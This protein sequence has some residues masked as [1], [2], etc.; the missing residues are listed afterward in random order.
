MGQRHPQNLGHSTHIAN[1]YARFRPMAKS[2][3]L[4][5]SPPPIGID[6]SQAPGH[7]R[8]TNVQVGK[9]RT[10]VHVGFSTTSCSI[11][12][13]AIVRKMQ[14]RRRYTCG[15]PVRQLLYKELV[16]A[17]YVELLRHVIEAH[18]VSMT[19]LAKAA[20]MDRSHLWRIL[21]ATP[22]IKGAVSIYQALQRITGLQLPP[23]A[24]P[25]A[26]REDYRWARIGQRLRKANPDRFDEIMQRVSQ[27]L[28]AEEAIAEAFPAAPDDANDSA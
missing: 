20:K 5:A 10:Q 8:L 15:R 23:P 26:S 12:S 22:T 4:P 19:A 14:H 25:V 16:D 24:V 11:P 18:N 6:H 3:N 27:V 1:S 7:F 9:Y 28:D 13:M 2:V 17:E 21:N